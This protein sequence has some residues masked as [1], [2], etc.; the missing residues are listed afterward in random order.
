LNRPKV[1][2][3]I[4]GSDPSGSAGI[5]Q[6]LKTFQSLGVWGCA[7]I[8][9]LTVQNSLGVDQT[10]P[11]DGKFVYK[12]IERLTIDIPI[13]A[14]KIGMLLTE[15]VVSNVSKA[16]EE[17]KLK[18]IVLD[19]VI[20]SKN[21]KF[22]LSPQALDIFKNKL[23]PLVDVVTPNIPEAE[24][25]TGIK[26]RS[27]SDM[28]KTAE[29]LKKL[30]KGIIVIKGGHLEIYKE[31]VV[32]IIFDGKDFIILEYPKAN[33]KPPRGTG[34]LFSSAIASYLAKGYGC[35]DAIKRAKAVINCAISNPINLGKGYP[36][37][38]IL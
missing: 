11:I 38:K 14:V 2:L 24:S 8:T 32:D 18:N 23:L 13:D 27:I 28:K 31:K 15:D 19:T 3:T 7:V 6:D 30:T 9:S 34:C 36:F 20:Q 33:T 37:I 1:T 10:M 22:L 12:Q 4:A 17:F 29:E 21:G 5:Q 25:L 16:I 26:I 35:I